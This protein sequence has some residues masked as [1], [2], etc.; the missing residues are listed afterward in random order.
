LLRSEQKKSE[1]VSGQIH[2][3]RKSLDNFGT[4]NPERHITKQDL[5]KLSFAED[6]TKLKSIQR[7]RLLE[8][9]STLLNGKIRD[10]EIHEQ[11][12]KW[13]E[14]VLQKLNSELSEKVLQLEKTNK[15]LADEKAHSDTLNKKLQEALL[16]LQSSEEQLKIER[17]WLAQQVEVKSKEVLDTISEMIKEAEKKPAQ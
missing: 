3:A 1:D 17:D 7:E 14:S 5:Q 15:Q 8:D 10:F 9:L 11:E 2:K 13:K 16:K 4:I 6:I 12:E